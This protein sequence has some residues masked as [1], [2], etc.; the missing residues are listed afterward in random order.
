VVELWRTFHADA[1]VIPVA[2]YDIVLGMDWL[3]QYNP[4]LCA[5]DQKWV[6]FYHE[7]NIIRLQGE[8]DNRNK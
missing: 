1:F 5:W 4:M 7:G 3:E 8:K 6:E 2:A